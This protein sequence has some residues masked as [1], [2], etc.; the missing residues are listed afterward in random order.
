MKRFSISVDIAAPAARTW[1]VMSDIG[2]WHEWTPSVTSIRRLNDGA[3]AVGSRAV[4]RQPK[5]PP[6]L[7][8]VTE[9]E[10][11]RSFTWVSRAP[12]IR[13]RACHW[14]EPLDSAQSRGNL[15]IE[16]HGLLGGIFARLT[17]GIT[18]RYL[19]LEAKG[20]KARSEDPGFHHGT[21]TANT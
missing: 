3:F 7:W 14:V 18:E 8:T 21:S 19:A 10:P 17:K 9:I 11:G 6:A 15:S 2:R 1:E 12:G 20:L 4:I 5:F 16:Y 13:V